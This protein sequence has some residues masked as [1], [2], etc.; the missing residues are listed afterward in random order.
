MNNLH[1]QTEPE[2][3]FRPQ[4]RL[5]PLANVARIM[6]EM[7]PDSAKISKD[8]KHCMQEIASE[9]I[10][11]VTSEASDRCALERRKTVTAEDILASLEA[12]GFD[13]YATLL[14]VYFQKLKRSGL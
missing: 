7:I 1:P 8:A 4:D 12:L 2:P 13:N 9:F 6:K 14:N 3:E 10:S 5:V 11:F